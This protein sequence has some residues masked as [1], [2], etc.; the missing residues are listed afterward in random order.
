MGAAG[1]RHNRGVRTRPKRATPLLP[2][3]SLYKKAPFGYNAAN[4]DE[5]SLIIRV[6]LFDWGATV[7]GG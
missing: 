3:P 4:M 1:A 5:M 2:H 7:N 6:V